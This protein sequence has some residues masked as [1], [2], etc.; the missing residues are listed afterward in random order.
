MTFQ[1]SIYH[2]INVLVSY[3]YYGLIMAVDLSL[4]KYEQSLIRKVVKE[5]M[6]LQYQYVNV[7]SS[8]VNQL[9]AWIWVE[10]L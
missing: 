10:I 4:W 2:S 1:A 3:A 8:N 6:E 7:R 5:Q 9:L